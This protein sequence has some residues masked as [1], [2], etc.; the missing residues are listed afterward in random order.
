MKTDRPTRAHVGMTLAFLLALFSLLPG[1]VAL[2]KGAQTTMS[3]QTPAPQVTVCYEK[4]LPEGTKVYGFPSEGVY[5]QGSEITLPTVDA[6]DY[7][8]WQTYGWVDARTGAFYWSGQRIEVTVPMTLT[9]QWRSAEVSNPVSVVRVNSGQGGTVSPEGISQFKG[10]E[11]PLLL[12]ITPEDGYE[13]QTVR[14]STNGGKAVSVLGKLKAKGNA[15]TYS[16]QNQEAYG[17]YYDVQ[18]AFRFTSALTPTPPTKSKPARTPINSAGIEGTGTPEPVVPVEIL[19]QPQDQKVREG[20]TA[21]FSV[22]ARGSEPIAYQWQAMQKDGSWRDIEGA[23]AHVYTLS[24]VGMRQ[25]GQRYRCIVQNQGRALASNEVKLTV[26]S[27]EDVPQTGQQGM[28]AW[29]WIGIVAAGTVVAG[30][31]L[32]AG[33]KKR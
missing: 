28:P 21:A 14:V 26:S 5:A 15:W 17:R 8:E 19:T 25:S 16:L 29:I 31:A 10:R 18:V 22:V 30:V 6:G 23:Q 12:T 32:W 4:N 3:A 11:N 7:Y 27:S 13:I 1:A 2:A 24:D 33:K 20:R 9:A